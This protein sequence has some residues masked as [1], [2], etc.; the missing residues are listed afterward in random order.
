MLA[1]VT[2]WEKGHLWG[3]CGVGGGI[4]IEAA[5]D[6][7][8]EGRRVREESEGKSPQPQPLVTTITELDE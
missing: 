4:P 6:R 5:P 2:S 3:T 8:Q 1:R 7:E